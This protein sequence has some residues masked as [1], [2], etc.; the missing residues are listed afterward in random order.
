MKNR[1]ILVLLIGCM[2][3]SLTACNEKQNKDE[4]S[5]DA[6]ESVSQNTDEE[7]S[8]AWAYDMYKKAMKTTKKYS[9]KNISLTGTILVENDEGVSETDLDLDFRSQEDNLS[10]DDELETDNIVYTDHLIANVMKDRVPHHYQVYYSEGTRYFSD[11]DG[12]YCQTIERQS[13]L[14]ELAYFTFPNLT[15]AAFA[16]TIVAYEE[17]LTEISLPMSGDV[18]SDQL[19]NAD[20]AISYIMG[21]LNED[22]TY[23]LGDTTVKLTYNKKGLII[24]YDLYYTVSINDL[25]NTKLSISLVSVFNTPGKNVHV[26][27]PDLSGYEEMYSSVLNDEAYEAMPDIVD[28]LFDKDGNRVENFKTIHTKLCEKY[29]K[30]VVD[31]VV[32]WFEKQL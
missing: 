13:A 9:G 25:K 28:Q 14:P 26:S 23:T 7:G 11:S 30:T 22:F 4:S 31:S 12:K 16:G 5:T 3:L 18:L 29:G 24:G 17:D 15:E 20:G 6:S 19:L 1:L 27:L 32:A 21:G 8:P 2:L 10:E